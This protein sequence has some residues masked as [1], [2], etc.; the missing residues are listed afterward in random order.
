MTPEGSTWGGAAKPA[1]H[2]YWVHALERGSCSYWADMPQPP[3][4]TLPRAH[5]LRK[6]Q[7][8][9]WEA[10][11]PQL[12]KKPGQQWGPS[13]AKNLINFFYENTHIFKLFTAGEN[14]FI[15]IK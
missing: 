8:P 12:Q 3:Q 2:N 5:A 11:A 15:F 13:A 6:E 7:S 10:Y 14:E 9:Q 4:P 1:G